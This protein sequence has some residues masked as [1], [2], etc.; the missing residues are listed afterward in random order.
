MNLIQ[1][2]VILTP[3]TH[4]IC[5]KCCGE[6]G[7]RC[8]QCQKQIKDK[9]GPSQLVRDITDKYQITKDALATFKKFSIRK[10]SDV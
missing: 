3:C 7:D 9:H 5:K 10:I 1:D 4:V 6:K 2:P 8:P